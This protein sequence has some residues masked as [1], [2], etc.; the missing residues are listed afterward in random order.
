MDGHVCADGWIARA[1]DDPSTGDKEIVLLSFSAQPGSR[2]QG[3]PSDEETT[4][5]READ[6]REAA[7]KDT[8]PGPVSAWLASY[9]RKSSREK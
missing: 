9:L 6:C 2:D 8:G 3:Q 4:G 1:V 5:G 7:E